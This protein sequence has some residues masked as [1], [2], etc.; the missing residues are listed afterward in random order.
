M[1]TSD[2]TILNGHH[3]AETAHLTYSYPFGRTRCLRR[4]WI[5]QG[6]KGPAK[7]RSRFVT[8]TTDKA[9]NIA[10]TDRIKR[11]GIEAANAWATTQLA[12]PGAVRWNNPH[13]STY[14][15]IVVMVSS[16]LSDGSGRIGIDFRTLNE[17]PSLQ[18]LN[19]FRAFLAESATAPDFDSTEQAIFGRIIRRTEA[20]EV[21]EQVPA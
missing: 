4:E 6:I 7:G 10:Y 12:I 14:A 9:F 8:Q 13:G 18:T 2:T 15:P 16:P 17:Y 5:E 19:A 20:A 21:P 3:S 11:D 1:S